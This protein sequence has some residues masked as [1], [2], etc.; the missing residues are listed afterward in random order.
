MNPDTPEKPLDG[1]H[2]TRLFA[3]FLRA[4]NCS[5]VMACNLPTGLAII[6]QQTPG[7]AFFREVGQADMTAIAVA[8]D[9]SLWCAEKNY[10]WKWENMTKTG[11]YKANNGRL[12]APRLRIF[13][14]DLGTRDMAV[15]GN[16]ALLMASGA[17]SIIGRAT[18]EASFE[19]VWRPPFITK[20]AREDRCGLS[21]I[22][23]FDQGRHCVTLWGNT[24]QP[25]AW[26]PN[27]NGGGC[28]MLLHDSSVFCEGLCLPSAP[29][30]RDSELYLL[31]VGT[32]EFGKVDP[33]TRQFVPLCQ[34]PGYPT[35]LAFVR[36]WAVISVSS[37][38][39]AGTADL[40]LPARE[41][42]AARK[43]TPFSGILLVDMLSGDIAHHAYKESDSF[44]VS[45]AAVL[46]ASPL[47]LALEP[48]SEQLDPLLTV[49]KKRGA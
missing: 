44:I 36:N 45:G 23:L 25:A 11:G 17:Y 35:G 37:Q 39:P 4:E 10:L 13:T 28:V 48:G 16:G 49:S 20:I 43:V 14:S 2:F 18:P 19:L 27:F 5:I 3:S 22:G 21:G 29:R 46:P 42:F 41:G 30:W 26:R 9:G 1:M 31:N 24:D 8:P 40:D 32:A 7:K 12:Y 6:G 15:D 33:V 38:P 34:C 47:A